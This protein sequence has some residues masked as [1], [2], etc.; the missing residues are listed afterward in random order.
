MKTVSI[1]KKE[2][3]IF[4]VFVGGTIYGIY[5]CIWDIQSSQ[6]KCNLILGRTINSSL[7]GNL[8][9]FFTLWRSIMVHKFSSGHPVMK[10]PG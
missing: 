5:G 6:Q 1:N 7:V 2:I 10:L 8:R 9:N 4:M 3:Q